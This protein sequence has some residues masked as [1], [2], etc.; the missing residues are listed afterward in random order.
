MKITGVKNPEFCTEDNKKIL[1][2]IQIDSEW[3]QFVA[4]SDDCTDHGKKIYD[5]CLKGKYG[6][7]KEYRDKFDIENYKSKILKDLSQRCYEESEK[8]LSQRTLLNIALGITS[9]YPDYLQ[10]DKG[11]A[12]V[13]VFIN[14]Y[15]D[16]LKSAEEKIK[17]AKAKSDVDLILNNLI[18]PTKEDVLKLIIE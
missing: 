9:G 16:I 10:G 1:C 13:V 3:C 4:T 12:N 17:S 7:V 18:F 15:R 8:I 2:N 14:I 6:V 11:K 5:D